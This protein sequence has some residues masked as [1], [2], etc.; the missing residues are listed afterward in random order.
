MGKAFDKKIPI[1][2]MNDVP[3]IS[4]REEIIAMQPIVIGEDWDK[5]IF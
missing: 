4:Y 1:Y 5:I 2:L 3:K